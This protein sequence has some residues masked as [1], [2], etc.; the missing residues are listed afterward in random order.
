MLAGPIVHVMNQSLATGV[1]PEAFKEAIVHPVHKGSGKSRTTPASYQL[2]S[3]LPAFSKVLET[4]VKEDLEAHLT[5]TS[6]L[7]NSQHG[8]SAS[9]AHA[10]RLWQWHM[11]SGWPLGGPRSLG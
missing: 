7:P 11:P 2:V 8:F 6:A 5:T 3:I 4:I 1:V 10:P 9:G